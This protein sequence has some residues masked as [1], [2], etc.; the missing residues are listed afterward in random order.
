MLSG[1]NKLTA[2][3]FVAQIV[4][5]RRNEMAAMILDGADAEALAAKDFGRIPCL[6]MAAL[7]SANVVDAQEFVLDY[8]AD[9]ADRVSAKDAA[10]TGNGEEAAT[11]GSAGTTSEEEVEVEEETPEVEEETPVVEEAPEVTEETPQG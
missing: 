8:P 5:P 10:A 2:E 7:I 11:D 6:E 9:P 3:E 1:N 4:Q